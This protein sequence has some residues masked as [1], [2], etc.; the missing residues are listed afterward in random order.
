MATRF[1]RYVFGASNGTLL[2]SWTKSK[3]TSPT[4]SEVLSDST[5]SKAR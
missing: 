2:T 5:A 3:Q 1:S 4:D